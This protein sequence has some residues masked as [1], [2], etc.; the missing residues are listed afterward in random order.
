MTLPDLAHHEICRRFPTR[1]VLDDGRTHDLSAQLAPH[2][3]MLTRAMDVKIA[4]WRSSS[5]VDREPIVVTRPSAPSRLEERAFD[6]DGL[7]AELRTVAQAVD[8]G[9]DAGFTGF[10]DALHP[11]NLV[12][13]EEGVALVDVGLAALRTA[14]EAWTAPNPVHELRTFRALLMPHGDERIRAIAAFAIAWTELRRGL[15]PLVD[16]EPASGQGLQRIQEKRAVMEREGTLPAR[17]F[18]GPFERAAVAS[19]LIDPS[20]FRSCAAYVAH[21]GVEV[22]R[23]IASRVVAPRISLAPAPPWFPTRTIVGG[24]FALEGPWS[25]EGSW[26]TT[27]ARDLHRGNRARVRIASPS[28]AAPIVERCLAPPAD[29]VRARYERYLGSGRLETGAW[30]A[31]ALPEGETLDDRAPLPFAEVFP[32][33]GRVAT[34]LRAAHLS[35]I[36]HGAV[37]PQLIHVREGEIALEGFELERVHEPPYWGALWS[38]PEQLQGKRIPATDQWGLAMTTFV[39]LVGRHY[40]EDDGAHLASQSEGEL[41]RASERAR[42]VLFPPHFDRWF[43][44]CT[45]RAPEDRFACIADAAWELLHSA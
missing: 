35:G 2:V 43:A 21:L 18:L 19:A 16:H 1:V 8:R 28:A 14:V 15:P 45:A 17:G 22:A 10:A 11:G 26:V 36:V 42:E 6:V 24:R 27:L 41:P 39:A 30:I 32:I 29:A 37:M 3:A 4:G 25:E 31:C 23:D 9:I 13:Y 34:I 12:L 7:V 44:R 38:A 33:I 20:R 40:F 5:R